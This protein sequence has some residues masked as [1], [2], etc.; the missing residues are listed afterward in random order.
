MTSENIAGPVFLMVCGYQILKI[1]HSV[2][3]E[4]TAGPVGRLWVHFQRPR[5]KAHTFSGPGGLQFASKSQEP[6]H[7]NGEKTQRTKNSR[8][9]LLEEANSVM[10]ISNP[11]MANWV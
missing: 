10:F 11:K 3:S 6:V 1:R 7:K 9:N 2:T 5:E 4:N 8:K